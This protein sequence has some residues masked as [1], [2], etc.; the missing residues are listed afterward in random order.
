M[1]FELP[2]EALVQSEVSL[3]V[4]GISVVRESCQEVGRRNRTP[5]LRERLLP[6]RVHSVLGVMGVADLVPVDLEDLDVRDPRILESRVDSQ[7]GAEVGPLLVELLLSRIL[8]SALSHSF[9]LSVEI[10]Q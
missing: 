5:C 1:Y 9:L 7:G 4:K 6:K 10:I 3:V 2:S 8:S